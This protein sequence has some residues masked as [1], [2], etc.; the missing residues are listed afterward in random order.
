MVPVVLRHLENRDAWEHPGIVDEDVDRT[1]LVLGEPG[2][3]V[4]ELVGQPR[5]LRD[6]AKISA[7][8]FSGSRDPIRLKM[9]NSIVRS[10]ACPHRNRDRDNL[11][12]S[13]SRVTSSGAPPPTTL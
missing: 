4:A 12:A 1:E 6:L 10:S 9:P 11:T 2:D 13:S 8:G 5:L 3:R 7:V